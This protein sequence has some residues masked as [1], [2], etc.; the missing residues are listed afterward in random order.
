[1]FYCYLVFVE[2]V[3]DDGVQG[4]GRRP[5]EGWDRFSDDHYDLPAG[6]RQTGGTSS[7]VLRDY[8]EHYR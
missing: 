1:M 2:P 4:D 5:G 3:V 6:F 7:E 8:R